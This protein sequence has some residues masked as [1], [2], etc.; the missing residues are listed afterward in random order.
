M[1]AAMAEKFRNDLQARI[2][3]DVLMAEI[4]R[5]SAAETPGLIEEISQDFTAAL[6][7]S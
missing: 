4:E 2:T 5:L 6:S 1:S 3:E 7:G